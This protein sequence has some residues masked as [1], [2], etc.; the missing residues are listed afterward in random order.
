M[1]RDYMFIDG[2]YLRV[3]FDK[4]M[5]EFYGLVPPIDFLQL[6]ISQR[7][8]RTYYYDAID[9]SEP[10]GSESME[11]RERRI[12][13]RGERDVLHRHIAEINGFHVREGYVRRGGARMPRR[14]KAV[15][16]QL[17]VDALEHAAR[18]NIA[19]AIILAGDLDFQPLF[20][21]LERLGVLTRLC[22]FRGHVSQELIEV[23]D[24]ARQLTIRDFYSWSGQSF[25]A[26]YRPVD[27]HQNVD[28]PG[29]TQL[30]RRGT[31]NGRE[32]G[33]YDLGNNGGMLH[34]AAVPEPYDPRI[35]LTH[36]DINKLDL[37]FRLTYGDIVWRT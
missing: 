25:Q 12:A 5:R 35:A 1:A 37:A 36:K 7:S 29:S 20:A 24:E 28:A 34:V 31:W 21:S 18:G 23:A 3:E 8:Q 13:Q 32:V 22:Y 9:H 27:I 15:D 17:A 2:N 16:V 10:D 14:Q 6:A 33:L 19:L 30:V 26:N 11:Q 4:Q